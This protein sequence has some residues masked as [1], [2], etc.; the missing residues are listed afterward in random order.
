MVGQ[1]PAVGSVA[2]EVEKGDQA[3]GAAL[4]WEG[5]EGQEDLLGWGA[6]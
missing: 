1:L 6:D 4:A 5:E 2:G 3:R